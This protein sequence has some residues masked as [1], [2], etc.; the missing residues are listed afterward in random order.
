MPFPYFAWYEK[1]DQAT[2]TMSPVVSSWGCKQVL[3]IVVDPRL[4]LDV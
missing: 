2:G 3:V 4:L 1:R